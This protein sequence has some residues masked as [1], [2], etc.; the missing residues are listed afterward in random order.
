MEN[1]ESENSV[2]VLLICAYPKKYRLVMKQLA[3]DGWKVSAIGNVKKALQVIMQKPPT[4]VFISANTPGISLLKIAKIITTTFNIPVI[5][6]A[7][8]QDFQT[9]RSL[10]DTK[11][12]HV[13]Q[14]SISASVIRNKIRTLSGEEEASQSKSE[15]LKRFSSGNTNKDSGSGLIKIEGKL[16]KSNSSD[17][18]EE[19]SSEDLEEFEAESGA[20][21]KKYKTQFA[22]DSDELMDA[23]DEDLVDA[24][25]DD[26]E[27]YEEGDLLSDD[28][29][30]AANDES[31]DISD[32]LNSFDESGE[33]VTKAN[34]SKKAK[35]FEESIDDIEK[36]IDAS[37]RDTSSYQGGK[38]KRQVKTILDIEDE[39]AEVTGESKKN[40]GSFS[41]DIADNTKE[42]A[43]PV[44]SHDK[45]AIHNNEPNVR[46][47]TDSRVAK[48]KQERSTK[49]KHLRV[50]EIDDSLDMDLNT[51]LPKQSE[52]G[53][54][55]PSDVRELLIASMNKVV[56]PTN[57][58]EH[59]VEMTTDFVAFYIQSTA[60]AGI[61]YLAVGKNSAISS[62]LTGPF[63][64]S[65]TDSIKKTAMDAYIHRPVIVNVEPM[66]IKE[67]VINNSNFHITTNHNGEEVLLGFLSDVGVQP[68]FNESAHK[69]MF[70]VD[71][72][73]FPVNYPVNMDL[74]VYLPLNKKAVKY[75]AKKGILERSQKNKLLKHNANGFHIL[76][77]DI[78]LVRDF[79][80][81]LYTRKKVA[82]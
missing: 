58:I 73:N 37:K 27:S 43:Y 23:V 33:K 63:L 40:K 72:Q 15:G 20:K 35:S 1:K 32:L 59:P 17:E 77:E 53:L 47:S 28:I 55:V 79:F 71:V 69:G 16:K 57:T 2:S 68:K 78:L 34:Q 64:K 50:T 81:Q 14:V 49:K 11:W 3:Q 56:K 12:Q 41:N 65:I 21:A 74:Y 80:V 67:W 30:D 6:F 61:M 44:A 76:N 29:L 25:L 26:L 18:Y 22:N 62:G 39:I 38:K 54:E 60:F 13:L 48:A 4:H 51:D 9:M 19:D 52:P 8:Q 31:E 24:S 75:I 45:H 7:E 66:N 10:R 5:L 42:E 70:Q 82:A 46:H 36:E